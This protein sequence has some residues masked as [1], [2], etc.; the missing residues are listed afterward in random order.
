MIVSLYQ[1]LIYLYQSP[2]MRASLREE[3][4]AEIDS[5]AVS[6]PMVKPYTPRRPRKKGTPAKK[7]TC[8]C[9]CVSLPD[10]PKEGKNFERIPSQLNQNNKEN[11]EDTSK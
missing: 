2:E 8:C 4:R 11:H 9:S 6:Q 5:I 7:K 10:L 1:K 3:P